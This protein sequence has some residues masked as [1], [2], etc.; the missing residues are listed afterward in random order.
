[1]SQSNIPIDRL[2]PRLRVQLRA[3]RQDS[4]L[5]DS[6]GQVWMELVAFADTD[7]S[8]FQGTNGPIQ[9]EMLQTLGLSGRIQFPIRRLVT[10]WKN[11]GRQRMITRW[12]RILI[13][14]ATF[15]VSLWEEMARFRIDDVINPSWMVIYVLRN[16][17]GLIHSMTFS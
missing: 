5:P 8:L 17:S 1:M 4:T 14:R 2:P 9:D 6:H 7:S 11:T 10:L 13:G 15:N 16:S 3:N 12:C